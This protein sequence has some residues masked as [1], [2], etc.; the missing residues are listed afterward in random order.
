MEKLNLDWYVPGIESK[1]GELENKINEI[2]D[3][4]NIDDCFKTLNKE[5]MIGVLDNVKENPI[6][7][8]KEELD[9]F[10]HILHIDSVTLR[11]LMNRIE[12]IVELK[13]GQ[14]IDIL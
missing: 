14:S 11:H 7:D 8:A 5:K 1:I 9:D 2:I 12:R 10:I 6:S 3:Y 4:I 13:T